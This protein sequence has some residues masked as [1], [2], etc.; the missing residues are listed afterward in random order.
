MLVGDFLYTRAFQMMV[1]LENMDILAHMA[2]TTNTIAAG[3]V[4]Q[5]ER[6]GNPGTNEGQYLEV[7]TRKTAVLFGAA[8]YGAAALGG[9]DP[10]QCAAL[11]DFGVNLGIAFQMIDDLLDYAGD[12]AT[13]GKN[14]G[15]DLGEGKVTLPLIHTMANA[16]TAQREL[17]RE[18]IL[19]RSSE[20]IDAVVA[21][22]HDCGA[23]AFTRERAQY[24]HDLAVASLATLPD[25]PAL[26][27][28][29]AI[30]ALSINRDQ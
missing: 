21:A 27:S 1:Q 15:D 24:F 11:R 30:T 19:A 18:A 17:V 23:L 3:E 5:L 29:R 8:G 25:S 4:L 22:V 12:P 6:A 9:A 2:D 28:L 16:S 10:A 7:I 20:H 13:M 26:E 14:V